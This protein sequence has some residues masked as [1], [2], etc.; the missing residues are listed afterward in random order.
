MRLYINFDLFF[1]GNNACYLYRDQCL[2]CLSA[3]TYLKS[4]STGTFNSACSIQNTGPEHLRKHLLAV[5]SDFGIRVNFNTKREAREY[6]NYYSYE[7]NRL[8]GF[9]SFN[10]FL[11]FL[12]INFILL[13]NVVV[14]YLL[15]YH[16]KYHS[17]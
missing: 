14:N 12:I 2:C 6:M 17:G 8:P 3:G 10:F 1:L 15:V 7:R 4:V 9:I 13:G 5:A 11:I 16:D